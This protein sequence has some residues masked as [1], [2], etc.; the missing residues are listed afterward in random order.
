MTSKL[1]LDWTKVTAPVEGV[2]GRLLVTRGNLIVA[3]QTILTS[4]VSQDPMWAYF[5]I[6]EPTVL[7]IGDLVRQ[8]KFGP[9]GAEI[10]KIPVHLQRANEKDFPHN[11][12]TLDFVNNQLDQATFTHQMRAVFPEPQAGQ[13]STAL[14]PEQFC[15]LPRANQ[16]PHTRRSW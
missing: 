15:G 14:H 4:I 13:R 7:K 9:A 12:A 8:G 2:I 6:D 16:P 1:N 10:A 3:N 5:D 11:E